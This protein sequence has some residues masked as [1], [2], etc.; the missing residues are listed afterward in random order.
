MEKNYAGAEID[1]DRQDFTKRLQNV[2]LECPA[3]Q[4]VAGTLSRLE[5]LKT[6]KLLTDIFDDSRQAAMNMIQ[7][8]I[9]YSNKTKKRDREAWEKLKVTRISKQQECWHFVLFIKYVDNV[10]DDSLKE[11]G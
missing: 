1:D 6:V 3:S 11:A 9:A 10:Q 5:G 8:E 2:M 7:F 4:G